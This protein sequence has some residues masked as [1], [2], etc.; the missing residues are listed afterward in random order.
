MLNCFAHVSR[1]LGWLTDVVHT[2]PTMAH[3][4]VSKHMNVMHT[5]ADLYVCSSSLSLAS[6]NTS[7]V[8]GFCCLSTLPDPEESYRVKWTR[9]GAVEAEMKVA[10]SLLTLTV[11]P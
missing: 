5:N 2:K 7:V 9:R 1:V 10:H 11:Q 3:I 4:C 8:L 6:P